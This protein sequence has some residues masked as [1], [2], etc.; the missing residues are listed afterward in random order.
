MDYL[1]RVAKDVIDD[2]I[3]IPPT[4]KLKTDTITGNTFSADNIT[5]DS[6]TVTVAPKI[7]TAN[8]LVNTS[9]TAD[10][11]TV[12]ASAGG[13]VKLETL[14]LKSRVGDCSSGIAGMFFTGARD[15]EF[16]AAKVTALCPISIGSLTSTSVTSTG[17]MSCGTNAMTCGNM[18]SSSVYTNAVRSTNNTSRIAF[19]TDASLTVTGSFPSL[20]TRSVSSPEQ[21]S[22]I[23][24]EAT[25]NIT[26]AGSVSSGTW[27]MTCGTVSCGAITCTSGS[28]QAQ[29]GNVQTGAANKLVSD[30]WKAFGATATIHNSS[31]SALATFST[32]ATV[33]TGSLSCG[34]I[35]ATGAISNGTNSST[36]GLLAASKFVAG[37]ST[38]ETFETAN[39]DC[40]ISRNKMLVTMPLSSN[41]NRIATGLTKFAYN[42]TYSVILRIKYPSLAL[43]QNTDVGICAT[44]TGPFANKYYSF[45]VV[46]W[47]GQFSGF[48]YPSSG[49]FAAR[50]T[51]P[52][53]YDNTHLGTSLIKLEVS[54]GLFKVYHDNQ[55]NGVTWIQ[56]SPGTTMTMYDPGETY[57]LYVRDWSTSS[58]AHTFEIIAGDS[59][60]NGSLKVDGIEP[61]SINMTGATVSDYVIDGIQGW[62]DLKS[63]I[64]VR[65]T[66]ANDPTWT[67]FR[68]SLYAYQFSGSTMQQCWL[69]F[70]IDHTYTP[71]S[72]VFFHVHW[73]DNQVAPHN[74]NVVW[75]FEYSIAKGHGQSAFGASAIVS[76]PAIVPTVQYRHYISEIATGISSTE[77]EVD[78]LLLVRLYRD[79]GGLDTNTDAIHV[80]TSDI[81]FQKS[82][83][84]TKNK[85]PNFYV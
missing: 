82:K 71:G 67:V 49:A 80:F 38:H 15:V 77:L 31:S 11:L 48:G 18:S 22:V 4:K 14:G 50:T 28:I 6:G 76:T 21:S 26:L 85:I 55:T 37:S 57:N 66:G 20:L 39:S 40:V 34:A 51:S 74:G 52:G 84:A 36:T 16:D 46:T 64:V 9:L 35:T 44:S 17:T 53:L 61:Q 5:F 30:Y 29:A 60:V 43:A 27:G 25:N 54:G 2:D 19:G 56:I 58:S 59:T 10:K 79:K 23:T 81:H 72:A 47:A 63:D 78:C 73:A 12:G 13:I 83:F 70:H 68:D 32:S 42:G 62:D 69:V 75:K 24:M 45:D 1:G 8:A 41:S 65:G 33:L 3:V 7:T